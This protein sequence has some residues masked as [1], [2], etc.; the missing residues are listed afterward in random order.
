LETFRTV[1]F[2]LLALII[3]AVFGA[4]AVAAGRVGRHQAGFRRA[5]TGLL[6]SLL[7]IAFGYLLVHN[8]Q[9]VLV[10]GQLLGPLLGN[11]VGKDWGNLH[12]PSPFNDSFEPHPHFLPS[13]FYWYV[14]VAV[15]IAVHVAAVL[16]AHRHL[17]RTGADERLRLR[18]EYPWLVAMVGY[19]CL[20]LWLLAQPLTKETS[21]TSESQSLRPPPV[22]AVA[23]P[24]APP[25]AARSSV[26]QR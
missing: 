22:V 26:G 21:T 5:F 3:A 14:S 7:P 13:A 12:L 10:N 19:T 9:Y 20:S 24:A 25:V 1:T 18:S 6:P 15:I 17:S 11:P 2:V 4:F 23:M 16:L 8:L